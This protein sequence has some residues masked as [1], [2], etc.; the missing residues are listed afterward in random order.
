[1]DHRTC[2]GEILD[3]IGGKDNLASAAHCATRLRLVIADNDKVKKETLENIDGVKGVFEAAGQLQIIIGTGTVNKVY[4]QFIDLAG[5]EAASKDDVKA[6]AAARAPWYKRAIKTLGDIFVPIIPAIVATGLLCGLLGGLSRAFPSLSDHYIYNILDLLSNTALTFL[7]ILIAVS[8]AKIFG[9]NIYLGAV[10]G[11][12]MIHPSLVNAW[13]IAGGA[14]TKTLWSWFGLWNIQNTGYQGHVIP[15]VIAV[16]VLAVIEKWLHKHVHEMFDLF[17]TPLVSVLITGFLTLTVI[18]PVFSQAES[19]VLDGAKWLITIPLGIGS[20]LMG[21]AYAPT[22]VAGVHHMYNAIELSM[23]ADNGKNIRMPIATAAN[24]AQGAAA[25]AVGI[26]S[27]NKKI[28]AMALPSSLS[29][30]MGITEPAIFGVNV[31][32]V[33][34]LIA[35]MIGGACGAAV[36]SLM[37]VFATANGVTG[38]FGFLIT[39]DS[40]LGYLLTFV[41]ASGV[42]F[43]ASWLMYKDPVTEGEKAETRSSADTPKTEPKAQEEDL[44]A[45][46]EFDDTAVYSPLKGEVVLMQDVPDET[47]AAEVLGKGAAVEPSEGRVVA[48]ADATVETLFD[49][50]HAIGLTLDNGMEILIHVGINTVEL[51]GEGYEAH[52]AEGDKVKR[53][54]TLI[55]F[56]K[57]LIQSKGYK[58]VT[59]VIITNADDYEEINTAASGSIGLLDK[60]LETKKG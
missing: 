57:A 4:D 21:A 42:A 3:A 15:V 7:P 55:T 24:V 39:T 53:G 40:F 48:P 23:L 31:R 49:T 32:F 38:L 34:P 27:R 28:K 2:A 12:L 18:G 60:L 52:V 58:T 1:M 11:M 16:L 25:L 20:F 13:S 29:A 9:A 36:A 26:K 22:V 30:F 17:V 35:G 45:G 47:F 43:I 33:R 44:T 10:I 5:V 50:H 56:D 37:N 41:V 14:E 19:W 54:Q 6:A 46:K 51:G 8:A 59:P